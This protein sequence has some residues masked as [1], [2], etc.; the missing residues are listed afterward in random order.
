LLEI[1]AVK[2]LNLSYQP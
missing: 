1:K 2:K